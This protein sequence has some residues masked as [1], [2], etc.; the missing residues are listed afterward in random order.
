MLQI[1]PS[2][3]LPCILIN[4]TASWALFL[5]NKKW[6]QLLVMSPTSI[7]FKLSIF[8]H[9][10]QIIIS[11]LTSVG[12]MFL[13]YQL[14]ENIGLFLCHGF[15]F[16]LQFCLQSLYIFNSF[17]GI[18]EVGWLDIWRIFSKCSW[19]VQFIGWYGLTKS[20]S[21]IIWLKG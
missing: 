5:R 11:C 20:N 1:F 14:N 18:I 2:K 7:L 6:L 17:L 21:L 9:N 12:I 10:L 4:L 16:V 19:K 13:I 15:S 3:I 8:M